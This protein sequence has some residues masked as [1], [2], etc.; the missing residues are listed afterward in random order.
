MSMGLSF[1]DSF[2]MLQ[3]CSSF[4]EIREYRSFW[5]SICRWHDCFFGNEKLS[6]WPQAQIN[7]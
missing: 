1:F 5:S 6:W 3:N 4:P 7:T 2:I